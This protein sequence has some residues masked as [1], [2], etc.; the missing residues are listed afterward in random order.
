MLKRYLIAAMVIAC[1]VPVFAR[2]W[3]YLGLT[4][5]QVLSIET[6]PADA[7]DIYAG[8]DGGTY[9]SHNGG[10][11]WNP[12]IPLNVSIP[13]IAFDP[14]FADTLCKLIGGG[15]NSAGLYRSGDNGSTWQVNTYMMNPRRMAFDPID[16]GYYYICFGDG[17]LATQDGGQGWASV[18][19]GLPAL[20]ILDVVGDGT[21]QWEAY[22]IGQTFVYHTTDI[23]NNWTSMGGPFGT[24]GY[25]PQRLKYA[26]NTPETLYVS[27]NQ[28]IVRS[29]DGGAT[30]H[31]TSMPGTNYEPIEC[32]PW[33]FGFVYV[34][35][36]SGGGVLISTDAGV[37]FAEMNDSLGNLNVHSL[38]LTSDNK[39]LAG[40]N[41]GI[42]VYDFSVGID[43]NP[44]LLPSQIALMQNYPNPFNG[45]T[46]IS[47]ESSANG[48]AILAI[49]DLAGRL[50]KTLYDG[51]AFGNISLI[52]DGCDNSGQPVSTGV[53]FYQL[54][55]SAGT[56]TCKMEYLK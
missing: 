54:K 53:Y 31:S 34:G 24:E 38:R 9:V 14:H 28:H 8:T 47:F 55:T 46:R 4:N 43:D 33:H 12:I 26:S 37:S 25:N 16:T 39:L 27:C 45:R 21:H 3:Q 41:D 30:W 5:K 52:W 20:D 23:G 15:S 50:V 40:T 35:S 44:I 36:T 19:A 6:N 29:Y 22:A 18:N 1:S 13:F 56:E 32:D 48:K 11:S 17:I 7:Q 10:Q 49:Y 51:N 2:H 42:Y